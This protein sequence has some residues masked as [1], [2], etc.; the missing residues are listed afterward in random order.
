MD[1]LVHYVERR[2]RAITCRL[3]SCWFTTIL[4]PVPASSIHL[5]LP[6]Y[7]FILARL[8]DEMLSDSF[9]AQEEDDI[10]YRV[11][12]KMIK[13]GAV[14]VDIG[15]N[16]A[17]GDGEGDED[18]AEPVEDG[19]YEVIDVVDCFRLENTV[20]DKKGYMAHIK[21]YMRAVKANLAEKNPDRVPVFEKAAA[22][23]VK[24][25]LENFSQYDFYTG[26]NMNPEAMVVLYEEKDGKTYMIYWKDGLRAEKY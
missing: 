21:E 6:T 12:C 4:F 13:K 23:Y 17:T 16:P 20:F 7:T 15:A 19:T 9:K 18:A 2:A 3:Q 22:A 1:R 26:E 8:G 25:V 10:V 11:E 14:Q 5:S 24:K